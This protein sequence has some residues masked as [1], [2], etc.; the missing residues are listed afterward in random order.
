MSKKEANKEQQVLAIIR[1]NPMLSQQEIADHVGISRSA[2]AGYVMKL[3]EKG[4]ILGKGYVLPEADFISVIGGANVDIQGRP[5]ASGRSGDSTPGLI[6][7]APGGVARN[8]AANLAMLGEATQLLAMVGR[9]ARGTWLVDETRLSGVDVS[10]VLLHPEL[11]TSTYLALNDHKGNM[12]R[13]VSDMRL[14]E[15]VTAKVLR[16]RQ[17]H[18]QQSRLIVA[19]TNLPDDTLEWLLAGPLAQTS[20]VFVDGVSCS[21]VMKVANYLAGIHTLKINL[22]EAE[23]LTALTTKAEPMDHIRWLLDHGLQRV[24]LSLGP[25]GVILADA[26]QVLTAKLPAIEVVNDTGAGDALMAGLAFG[27]SHQFNPQQQLEFALGCA[28]LTLQCQEANC[29]TLSKAKVKKW[30]KSHPIS[31]NTCK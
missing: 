27:W 5:Q 7:E 19:D 9:D 6:W 22:A 11:P 29:P 3:V 28:A 17:F 21:K 30:T 4:Q 10:Q 14:M 15:Q 26:T 13:A 20:A 12:D 31:I 25:N 24:L 23:A 8:I 18:L 16:D 1:K 2:V